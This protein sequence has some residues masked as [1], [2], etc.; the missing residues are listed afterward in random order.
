MDGAHRKVVRL[1]KGLPVEGVRGEAMALSPCGSHRL[2][3]GWGHLPA[4]PARQS[5][6]RASRA[7]SVRGLMVRLLVAALGLL[8]RTQLVCLSWPPALFIPSGLCPGGKGVGRHRGICQGYLG[9][10]RPS[11]VGQTPKDVVAGAVAAW[12]G[13]WEVWRRVGLNPS[14]WTGPLAPAQGGHPRSP[15]PYSLSLG[16]PRLSLRAPAG[17]AGRESLERNRGPEV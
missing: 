3:W 11:S 1:P 12:A 13:L 7:S 5:V 4:W 6:A 2:G 8:L 9:V 17:Q 10:I 16:A 15:S 14:L